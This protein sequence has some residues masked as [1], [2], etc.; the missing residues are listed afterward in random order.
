MKKLPILIITIFCVLQMANSQNET[1]F[2]EAESFSDKGGWVIDQQFMDVMGSPFLMAHGLGAPVG[3]AN[4]NIRIKEEGKYYVFVRT[5]NWN[6]KWNS[7]GAAGKFQLAFDGESLSKTFGTGSENWTWTNG[8]SID[9]KEK[10][11]NLLL[12][13]LTGFNGRCDAIII[14]NNPDFNPP[15]GS[16]DLAEFRRKSLGLS[17]DPEKAGDFDLVVVGG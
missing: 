12:K 6:K 1:I 11:Y 5:R 9:L 16:N 4:T 17:Q 15:N 3:D 7:K 2:I 14:T 13:D 8:G 10:T